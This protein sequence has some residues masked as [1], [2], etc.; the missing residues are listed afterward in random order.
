MLACTAPPLR[1]G[2]RLHR[3]VT[4]AG[5]EC[6]RIDVLDA[7]DGRHRHDRDVDAR[8]RQQDDRTPAHIGPA[9]VED[10]PRLHGFAEGEPP[11]RA[12]HAQWDQGETKDERCR[13]QKK[14]D[15]PHVGIRMEAC[16]VEKEEDEKEG[17]AHRREHGAQ[18]GQPVAITGRGVEAGGRHPDYFL[19]RLFI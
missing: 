10:G 6:R 5:A 15:D 14:R 1:D 16:K 17:A 2:L 8:E 12:P 9:K 13:Q 18:K 19:S 11:P 7:L 3:R 4:G